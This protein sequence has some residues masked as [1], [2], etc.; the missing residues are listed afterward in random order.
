MK[1]SL[2]LALIIY[3]KTVSGYFNK[4]ASKVAP[5]IENYR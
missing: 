2:V 5:F 3:E 1:K 4:I